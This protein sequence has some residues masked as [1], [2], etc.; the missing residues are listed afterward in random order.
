M[1]VRRLWALVFHMPP[2]GALVPL[3]QER[4]AKD[5]KR[6]TSVADLSA[7]FSGIN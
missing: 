2:D 5:T 6:V 4:G 3:I 1:C 7:L